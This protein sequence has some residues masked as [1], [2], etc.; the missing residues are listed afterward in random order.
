[1][2]ILVQ[3]LILSSLVA[4]MAL[5]MLENNFMQA[6]MNRF[7]KQWLDTRQ[8]VLQQLSVYES[9]LTCDNSTWPLIQFVD[10]V[11]YFEITVDTMQSVFAIHCHAEYEIDKARLGRRV[12][13][14][15]ERSEAMT[16]T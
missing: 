7:L 1:M 9:K 13:H 5:A 11:A 12:L 2:G 3:M 4:M 14:H 16:R 8:V 10:G 6:R 15:C